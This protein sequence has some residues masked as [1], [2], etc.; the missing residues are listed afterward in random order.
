M[1]TT[2]CGMDESSVKLNQTC[3]FF[4]LN[5]FVYRYRT[6]S[7]LD[8]LFKHCFRNYCYCFHYDVVLDTVSVFRLTQWHW[9]YI[10][11]VL[12]V[13]TVN[14]TYGLS[15]WYRSK[16]ETN[17]VHCRK[18]DVL[19]WR[20]EIENPIINYFIILNILLTLVSN[21]TVL[22]ADGYN[23]GS[24]VDDC[25]MVIYLQNQS[26]NTTVHG[27]NCILYYHSYSTMGTHM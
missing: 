7:L 3:M 5:N 8:S 13:C 23:I 2:V 11:C 16:H 25:V 18:D 22:R 1:F 27:C 21:H 24:W 6:C 10:Q 12:Y 26:I 19:T 20:N 14:V 15:D 4:T 17:I 9:H